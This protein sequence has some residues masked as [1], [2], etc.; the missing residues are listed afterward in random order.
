MVT[1][2]ELN[3]QLALLKYDIHKELQVVVREQIRQLTISK[4]E[5]VVI[6][7]KMFEK[8]NE[9]LEANKELRAENERLRRIY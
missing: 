4:D 2:S 5:T 9:L 7:E 8:M 1:S 6:I 3:E